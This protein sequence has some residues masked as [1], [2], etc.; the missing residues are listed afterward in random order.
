MRN[1]LITHSM[2]GQ[3]GMGPPPPYSSIALEGDQTVYGTMSKTKHTIDDTFLTMGEFHTQFTRLE[4]TNQLLVSGF[5]RWIPLPNPP[6]QK[7]SG[8][9]LAKA[10]HLI[11][12]YYNQEEDAYID[13]LDRM[14]SSVLLLLD[15]AHA[16]L[17]RKV[18]T[19]RRKAPFTITTAIDALGTRLKK[20][21]KLP[22]PAFVLDQS[23]RYQTSQQKLNQTFELLLDQVNSDSDYAK[24]ENK[25]RS[26]VYSTPTQSPRS[27]RRSSLPP[28]SLTPSSPPPALEKHAYRYDND[29]HHYDDYSPPPSPLPRQTME[30]SYWALYDGNNS[31]EDEDLEDEDDDKDAPFDNGVIPGSDTI[32]TTATSR[33]RHQMIKTFHQSF[34]P[35]HPPPPRR[36]L[37]PRPP[38]PTHS[39]RWRLL[40]LYS[41]HHHQ[42]YTTPDANS[43]T[44]LHST[45]L[46]SVASFSIAI[47]TPRL[48][49]TAV[50]T[51]FA[52][53]ISTCGVSTSWLS[54]APPSL[55]YL[56]C[57]N[58][59]PVSSSSSNSPIASLLNPFSV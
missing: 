16:A 34:H 4:C 26:A 37:S 56:T 43:F 45:L 24:K 18:T 51:S 15:E 52:P 21:S 33:T 39:R 58:N 27:I 35:C 31:D 59:S 17:N 11:D 5:N 50:Y 9:A 28:P 30:L 13:L 2:V 12:S 10:R 19:R 46:S 22:P 55:L 42:A 41:T 53:N 3:P 1:D 29:H 48:P 47:T 36:P 6:P 8:K 40:P 23:S 32:L 25:R 7:R 54:L 49:S 14:T 44:G 57:V 20:R 38:P